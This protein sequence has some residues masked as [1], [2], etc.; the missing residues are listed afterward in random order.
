MTEAKS[1]PLTV[2]IVSALWTLVLVL[3][4]IAWVM[5][6]AGHHQVAVMFGF[7]SCVT[8]GVAAVFSL[9]CSAARTRALLR[10]LHGINGGGDRTSSELHRIR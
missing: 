7:T 5:T 2:I 8:T 3:L 6:V 1:I 9:R 10:S 4:G